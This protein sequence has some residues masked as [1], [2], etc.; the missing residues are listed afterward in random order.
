MIDH[1]GEGRSKLT[2]NTEVFSGTCR[3]GDVRRLD[4]TDSWVLA[5]GTSGFADD[6]GSGII[7][8]QKK[9]NCDRPL[10]ETGHEGEDFGRTDEDSDNQERKKIRQE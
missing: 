5:Q 3:G 7:K 4:I 8:R 10:T 2:V 1:D 9:S 6:I